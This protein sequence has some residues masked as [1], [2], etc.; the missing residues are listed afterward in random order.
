MRLKEDLLKIYY[1]MEN[2]FDNRKWGKLL[3]K[4]IFADV[5]IACMLMCLCGLAKL[6]YIN[7]DY[8]IIVVGGIGCIIA[9][10]H[11]MLP[12]RTPKQDIPPQPVGENALQYDP[13][14]MEEKYS[15]L[16]GHLANM[17]IEE[18]EIL[19]LQKPNNPQQLEAPLHWEVKYNVPFYYYMA[20]KT[21]SSVDTNNVKNVL[22]RIIERK[23]N[24]DELPGIYPPVYFFN[25]Q[26]CP[27]I[28]VDN[29][30]ETDNFVQ[31]DIV[32]TNDYYGAYRKQRIYNSQRTINHQP[33][34]KEF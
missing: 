21:A 7:I 28:V 25:G 16:A 23:L 1:S 33:Q 13:V 29:I 31:I 27:A 5:V 8:I 4:I 19:K 30:K 15:M 32:W 12:K 2:D 11:S 17:L 34:D 26:P 14:D 18:S 3:V 10:I 9:L 6:I 22:Q 20:A 24:N